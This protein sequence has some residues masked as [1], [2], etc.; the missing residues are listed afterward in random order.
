MRFGYLSTFDNPL[1]PLYISSAKIEKIDNL[2]VINDSLGISEKD[3]KI[4]KLRTNGFFGDGNNLKNCIVNL[5]NLGIPIYVVDNHNSF[6]AIN[7]YKK[8]KIDCLI[9][10]GTPRKLS[11]KVLCST[12]YGVI[13]IHPGILPQY[14]G[15]SCVEWAIINDH[16]IGNTAHFMDLNYDT[17]PI[18]TNEIY[19][20]D[21]KSNYVEIRN[22]VYQSGC[23]LAA[24][25]IKG[26]VNGD[27]TLNKCTIQKESE[28]KYWEPIS[29]KLELLSIDKANRGKYKYQ[30]I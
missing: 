26:I 15:C 30:E 6:E 13:N 14:R 5:E 18:I 16:P 12:N 21:K 8:L 2:V 25:V 3:H 20:F 28:G 29:S 9:N 1:L 23:L 10:A 4:F 17:G 24:K 7:L 27:F 11:D 19:T 22:K